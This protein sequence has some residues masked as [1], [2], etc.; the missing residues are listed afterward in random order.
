MPNPAERRIDVERVAGDA[1][2]HLAV[3][4]VEEVLRDDLEIIIGGVIESA[5]AVTVAQ[6][7]DSRDTRLQP[8]VDLDIAALIHLDAGFFQAQIV[9][10]GT[11]PD[12]QQQ[13][14]ANG[15]WLA[16]AAVEADRDAIRVV[17]EMDAFGAGADGN[18][19][20]FEDRADG[21]RHL[22]VLAADQPRPL[23]DHRHPRSETCVDLREFQPDI[24]AADHNQ[25]LGQHVGFEERTVGE[26]GRLADPRHVRH[27]GTAAD[28]DEDA[29]RLQ[30]LVADHAPF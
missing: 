21:V 14:A 26:E 25:M 27:H 1:V 30:Q 17:G 28:I 29:V 9:G 12:R 3:G 5:A 2:A 18:A 22:W 8:I 15:L 19:L 13:M 11:P 7:P 10:V 20:G 24:A 23:L 16:L 6:R 4:S